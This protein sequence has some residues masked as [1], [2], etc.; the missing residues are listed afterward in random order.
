MSMKATVRQVDSVTV[1]DVSGRITLGEACKELRELIRGELGKGHKNLLLNLADV[2]YI[3]SS[4]IGELVSAFTAVS[5]Q[6]GKLKLLNLTKKVH[7]LLQITKLYTVFD[8]HND[9]A[10]AIGSF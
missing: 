8:I 6:G 5:S 9:E 1:V 10:K 3:D 7:D 4:G 2:T